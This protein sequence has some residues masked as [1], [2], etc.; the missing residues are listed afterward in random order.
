MNSTVE[1]D[2]HS[3]GRVCADNYKVCSSVNVHLHP[4][5]GLSEQSVRIAN[6]PSA[7]W[8]RA[9]ECSIDNSGLLNSSV[10][11]QRRIVAASL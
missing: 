2:Q 4:G 8:N 1:E 11:F 6:I 3:N 9:V 5:T 7:T 10:V